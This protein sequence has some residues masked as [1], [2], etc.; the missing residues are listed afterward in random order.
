V[1][2]KFPI[3]QQLI[4]K[5]KRVEEELLAAIASENE[6]LQNADDFSKVRVIQG[7]IRAYKTLLDLTRK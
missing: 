4:S 2:I 6:L 7:T 3:L 5:N 1:T